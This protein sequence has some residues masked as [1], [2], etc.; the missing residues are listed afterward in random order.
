M[1]R[2]RR[3]LVLIAVGVLLVAGL[4]AGAVAIAGDDD[5]AA[6]ACGKSVSTPVPQPT[7]EQLGAAG[8]AKQPLASGRVDL[9]APPFSKPTEITNPLFPISKL[10]SAV[11]NGTVEDKPFRTETTL[12]PATAVLEWSEGQC[13]KVLVSQYLAYLGGRIHEVALDHYAQAD[14]GSV[15]YLGENVF[16]YEDGVIADLEGT[17]LAGD[18][19]PAAMIMPAHPQVGET[20][21]P[22]NIAGLV[23]EEVTVKAVDRT[24]EGPRG[25]VDGAIEVRELH[26]DGTTED[27]L[28]APGYGEFF[29]GSRGEVEAMALAVPTDAIPGGVPDDLRT[30][31]ASAESA[32]DAAGDGRWQQAARAATAVLSAWN[33]HE[34]A[35]RVPP[36]LA[37]P[38][39]RASGALAAAVAARRRASAQQWALEVEQAGLDLEL[40]YRSPDQIDLRRLDLWLRRLLVD[41]RARDA[42]AVSGDVSTA[43]WIRD[44]VVPALGA[45]ELA[46]VD[47]LLGELRANAADEDFAAAAT[48]A[49]ELRTVLSRS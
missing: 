32:Y 34:G 12:L 43:E 40:Q 41:A 22:E 21:R 19:G 28:F 1:L 2:R 30:L 23:F 46:R 47:S 20:Y 18:E 17:W 42:G 5:S 24:V 31:V 16:N 44:R 38:L 13:V 3:T 33:R 6:G 14:D 39:N 27:K 29:T 36:R 45:A 9:V 11:L 37:P 35:A 8:L 15:W 4:A 49:E 7:K 48:T 26:D 10:R 25:S